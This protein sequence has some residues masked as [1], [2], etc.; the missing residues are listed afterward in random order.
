MYSYD[1]ED[2][3][4]MNDDAMREDPVLKY[5]TYSS[6]EEMKAD[7]RGEIPFNDPPADGCWNCMNFD[8]R[9]EACT[10]NWNNMDEDYYNPD[11]D[12]RKLTDWCEDHE[13]DP[14]AVWE[15]IFDD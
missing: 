2:N 9:H 5:T 14:D 15:D 6:R 13:T 12:D 4:P 8:W 3:A 7:E 10:M 1:D 11:C